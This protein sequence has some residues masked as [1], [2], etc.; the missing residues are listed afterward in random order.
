MKTARLLIAIGVLFFGLQLNAQNKNPEPVAG[1][2]LTKDY[3]TQNL[4]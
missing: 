1:K 4:V 3:I 2:N